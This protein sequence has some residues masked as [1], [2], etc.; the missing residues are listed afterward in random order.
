LIRHNIMRGYNNIMAYAEI[1]NGNGTKIISET[2]PHTLWQPK[3]NQ[4][5]ASAEPLWYLRVSAMK[6]HDMRGDC[7]NRLFVCPP[8]LI[9]PKRKK[10]IR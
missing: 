4:N 9:S 1:L 5:L 6:D 10:R 8:L 7:P 3:P 2:T